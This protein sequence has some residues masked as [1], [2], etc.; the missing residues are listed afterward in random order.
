[1]CDRKIDV[2]VLYGQ[3]TP[4]QDSNRPPIVPSFGTGWC[5]ELKEF[6]EC[7]RHST[8]AQ[9]YDKRLL[10]P[11]WEDK[12]LPFP[13]RKPSRHEASSRAV[14]SPS[15]RDL[16]IFCW[17]WGLRRAAGSRVPKAGHVGSLGTLDLQG[18]ALSLRIPG[19]QYRY[20]I[21]GASGPRG[22]CLQ[23]WLLGSLP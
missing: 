20:T 1:M 15:S 3:D 21:R 12:N 11:G 9:Y 4:T 22:F 16:P 14:D 18:S 17:K 2:D 13:K 8:T 5:L 19:A 10:C 7:Q 23:S 6:S